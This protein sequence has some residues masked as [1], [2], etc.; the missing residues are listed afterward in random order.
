MIYP[1]LLSVFS[2]LSAGLSSC[3]DKKAE[4][5][6]S[7]RILV[8]YKTGGYYHQSIPDGIRAIQTLGEENR[9]AVDTTKNAGAFSSSN[10]K[11]YDAVVFLNTTHEVLDDQQQNAFEQYI[12]SGKGFV[13][14]HA[15]TD[16]EYEWPWFNKLVGAYFTNHPK[17]QEA[18][19]LVKD[20]NHPSTS[21]LPS[22]WVHI[23]EWYNFKNI[24]PDIKVLA[25]LDE[26]SYEG[27]QNGDQHP[28]AWYHEFD[29]GRAFYTGL[30]H[31]S[32][33]YREPMFL[34]HLLG[35]IV[36]A[37]GK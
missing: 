10:L 7:P 15:A 24:N 12:R 18:K 23:D 32:E 28:I 6:T 36:Y 33:S 21:H 17:V 35:G 34:K 29:G 31:T 11:K 19:I 9:F 1:I 13:G 4:E 3:H 14:V 8:F 16:T 20:K 26:K 30:G 5:Q 37:I 22:V 25:W 2:F 27:G